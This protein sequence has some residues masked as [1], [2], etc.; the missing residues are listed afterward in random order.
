MFNRI[1]TGDTG[2]PVV[3]SEFNGDEHMAMERILQLATENLSS[4][5][6]SKRDTLL[7][8]MMIQ[9]LFKVYE[10]EAP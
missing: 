8:T 10:I 1:A 6:L 9:E 3:L 5:Q 4:R 2:R 7:T